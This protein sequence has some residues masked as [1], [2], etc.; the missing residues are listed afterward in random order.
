MA[1]AEPKSFEEME[2]DWKEVC[3]DC[4]GEKL[5]NGCYVCWRNGK[6]AQNLKG[7]ERSNENGKR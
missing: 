6:M 2:A 1:E 7:A 3:G 5:G 4:K